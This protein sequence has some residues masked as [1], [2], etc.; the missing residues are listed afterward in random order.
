MLL[1][2][3]AFDEY[4]IMNP[5]DNA[6]LA[7]KERKEFIDMMGNAYQMEGYYK[8][9]IAE[10]DVFCVHAES[11]VRIHGFPDKVIDTGIDYTPEGALDCYRNYVVIDY[12]TGRTIKH[13]P[14][15]VASMIQCTMYSYIFDKYFKDK[16]MSISSFE[17]WYIRNGEKV[18]CVD[19]N[20]TMQ[21]HYDNLTETLKQI[22]NSLE[23]GIFKPDTKHCGNCY[24]NGICIKKK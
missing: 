24:Y 1:A 20:H 14:D 19:D 6:V 8:T 16:G 7:S 3:Q 22:K 9:V 5:P 17:Y 18:Y 21:F 11:G 15:D 13:D 23:T 2:G 12:K 10:E 4:L